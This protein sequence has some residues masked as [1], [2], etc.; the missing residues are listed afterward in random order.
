MLFLLFVLSRYI[1]SMAKEL[2]CSPAARETAVHITAES[3]MYHGGQSV[4][5]LSLYGHS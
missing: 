5:H 2:S 4:R 3:Y 1:V